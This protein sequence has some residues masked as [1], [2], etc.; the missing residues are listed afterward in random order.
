MFLT[1][2]LQSQKIP[3]YE[4]VPKSQG[5]MRKSIKTFCNR[6]KYKNN[7]FMSLDIV[8]SYPAKLRIELVF[9]TSNRKIEPFWNSGMRKGIKTCF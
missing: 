7:P 5:I 1:T 6:S 2:V 3:F 8:A 4:H 9:N